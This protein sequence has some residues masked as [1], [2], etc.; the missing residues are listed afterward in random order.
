MI[1]LYLITGIFS[2]AVIL[3]L[4]RKEPKN[5][6]DRNPYIDNT[7]YSGRVTI[8]GDELSDEMWSYI[9]AL[10]KSIK[11]EH[12]SGIYERIFKRMLDIIIS[13]QFLLILSPLY[14]II[15]IAIFIDDPGRVFFTQRRVGKGKTY[16]AMHKFRTMKKSAPHNIPTHLLDNP[17]LYITRVGRILRHT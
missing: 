5:V 8:E 17:D 15:A 3:A 4:W 16:F 10:R 12:H 1:V 11:E 7:I 13:F 2:V 9:F 6:N 14:L